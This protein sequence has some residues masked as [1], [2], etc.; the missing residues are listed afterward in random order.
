[1]E[2]IASFKITSTP[3]TLMFIH[4]KCKAKPSEVLKNKKSYKICQA[5]KDLLGQRPKEPIIAKMI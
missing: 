2:L 5:R 3:Q 1:M 4:S